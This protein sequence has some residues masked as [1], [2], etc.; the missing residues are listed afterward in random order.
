MTTNQPTGSA[1]NIPT[2]PT[3]PT[4]D[5][6]SAQLSFYENFV[7][8]YY[9]GMWS[10][11]RTPNSGVTFPYPQYNG[12][13]YSQIA[14]SIL[15]SEPGESPEQIA[16]GVA[17]Q[18]LQDEAANAL[19]TSV[20]GAAGALGDVATGIQTAS[21]V[22]SWAD[23]LAGFLSDLTSANLW[24]RVAKIGLGGAI[25]LVGLAKLTGADQKLGGI[26]AKAVKAAP[27]L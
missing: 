4:G 17:G 22:P 11:V 6:R 1:T 7:N 14:T 2:W 20:T 24:I 5:S 12:Q 8:G 16:Q 13:T 3:A 15:S 19:D 10:K 27:L 23:G 9:P 18:Y 26:T 25:L 21:I